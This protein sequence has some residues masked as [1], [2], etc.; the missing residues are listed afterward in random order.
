MS[1]SDYFLNSVN[2]TI[3]EN[4]RF[5]RQFQANQQ[6]ASSDSSTTTTTDTTSTDSLSSMLN[7]LMLMLLMQMMGQLSGNTQAATGL[8]YAASLPLSPDSYLNNGVPL[9]NPAYQF[10]NNLLTNTGNADAEDTDPTT[11]VRTALQQGQ[12]TE[13]QLGQSLKYMLDKAPDEIAG[14]ASGLLSDLMETGDLNVGPFLSNDYLERL[15]TD[16]RQTLLESV[17]S[18]GLRMA[19]GQP[20]SRFIGFMLEQ[21][22]RPGDSTT[23][24]FLQQFLQDFYDAY[25]SEPDT[26]VGST[27]ATVLNLANIQ[28]DADNQLVFP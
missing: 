12:F 22:G 25:G 5:A 15:S 6:A 13:A 8:P 20:N 24:Q 11:A 19:N 7:P 16:R 18:S 27:L 4:M 23:K 9:Q 21:L 10:I 17:E 1:S 2:Q 26:P 14:Q 28:P 3:G